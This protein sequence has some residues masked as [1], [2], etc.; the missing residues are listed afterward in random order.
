MAK[1]TGM[2]SKSGHLYTQ[3]NEIANA[4]IHYQRGANG[5]LTEVERVRTGGAGSGEFKPIS[6]QDS[7]PNAFEGASSIF[8]TPDR[9]F[10]FTTNGG[11][12]TVSSFKLGDDGRLMLL[13][14]KPT[15]N[16][17]EVQPPTPCCAMPVRP[18]GD[19]R[20]PV[21]TAPQEG[22]QR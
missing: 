9:R 18:V 17:V 12:N 16:P 1:E 5:M 20:I 4:I 3:T 8:I 22:G 6:G 7:A 13:D 21:V 2:M 19:D 14:V 15:G 11:D 10:L